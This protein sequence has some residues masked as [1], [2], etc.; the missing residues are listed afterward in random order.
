MAEIKNYTLNFV[1]GR[2]ALRALTCAA[3]KLACDEIELRPRAVVGCGF[4]GG[5]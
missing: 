3:R 2:R 1:F 4:E 5:L